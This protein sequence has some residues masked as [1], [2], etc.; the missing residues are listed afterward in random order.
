MGACDSKEGSKQ[1]VEPEQVP[2][3]HPVSGRC[4]LGHGTVYAAPYP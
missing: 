4:P 3:R 1:A 2:V